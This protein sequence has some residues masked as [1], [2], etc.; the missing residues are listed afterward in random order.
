LIDAKRDAAV[1]NGGVST[2]VIMI[3]VAAKNPGCEGRTPPKISV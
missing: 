2:A 3:G 1:K